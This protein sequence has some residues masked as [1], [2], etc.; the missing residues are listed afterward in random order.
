MRP[1]HRSPSTS[2]FSGDPSLPASSGAAVR[3]GVRI[4]DLF[5]GLRR[6]CGSLRLRSTAIAGLLLLT[7]LPAGAQPVPNVN[8]GNLQD[9]PRFVD[10]LIDQVFDGGAQTT[11]LAWGDQLARGVAVILFV[12]TGARIALT[13]RFDAWELVKFILILA[14]PIGLLQFYD[15]PFVR[16]MD[17]PRLV[18]AQ[19]DAL[20]ALFG[21]DIL[22]RASQEVMNLATIVVRKLLTETVGATSIPGLI[23]GVLVG[24]TQAVTSIFLF[25]IVLLAFA[26]GMIVVIALA[27]AQIIFAKIAIAVLVTLGPIF[28]PFMI[29]PKMDFLFWGWFKAIIQYSLYSAIAAAMVALW[30]RII[31]GYATMLA[32]ADFSI[33]SQTAAYGAYLLPVAVVIVCAIVSILKIGDIAG[34]IVGAGSDG[35]GFFAGAFMA[36]RIVATP[37]RVV[38]GAATAPLKGGL[39]T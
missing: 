29:V 21:R 36:G 16:G 6:F 20:S 19:G 2:A 26:L 23:Q 25:G 28:I 35:G 3:D 30:A 24:G 5:R 7:A 15:A 10:T 4:P 1:R 33:Q 31:M 13:G 34:M 27:F 39:P 18:T 17:F 32:A 11:V 9:L 37:A 22:S 8:E 14:I 12:W 38:G